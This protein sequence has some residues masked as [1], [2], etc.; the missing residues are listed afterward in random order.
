MWSSSGGVAQFGVFLVEAEG[1]H[2]H[3]C[4]YAKSQKGKKTKQKPLLHHQMSTPAF[5]LGL[6]LP[7]PNGSAVH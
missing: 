2:E 4:A 6:P 1:V 7:C 5:D 3:P